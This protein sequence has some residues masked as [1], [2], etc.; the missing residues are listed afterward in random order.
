MGAHK[1]KEVIINYADLP[2]MHEETDY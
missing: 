2:T 1:S